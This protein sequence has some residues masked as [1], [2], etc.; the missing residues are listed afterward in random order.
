MTLDFYSGALMAID[1]ARS[2]GMNINVKILDS[3]ENKSSSNVANLIRGNNF[4]NADAVIGPFYQQHSETAAQMLLKD[5]I[6]VISPLSKEIGTTYANLYQTMPSADATKKAILNYMVSK[7]GNIIVIS[8]PKKAA[9]REFIT[10]NYPQA[11]FAQLGENGGLVADNL[12]GLMVKDRIN[13]VIL[14][15]ERTGMILSATNL[16]LNEMANFKIQLAIIEKNETLDFEEISMKR[17]T[18]LKMLYPSLT[19]ENTSDGARI[20]EKTYKEKNKMFPSQYATRGFD[21]TFDTM[22]RISQDKSY[23]ATVSEDKTEQIE[24]KFNYT[25]GPAGEYI[26]NGI[27]ILHYDEDLTVKEAE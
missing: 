5:S 4:R 27:Y 20:F 2:L 11:R 21:V 1:S 16:L 22:L 6:P 23:S 17:L 13:Y 12:R 25:R 26:N 10:H 18:I 8:D 19:R 9:N 14:D 7:N 24:S 15:S 3:E